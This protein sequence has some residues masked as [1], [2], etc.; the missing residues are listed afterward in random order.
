MESFL[1]RVSQTV[2][3][4]V[5][6]SNLIVVG[7]PVVNEFLSVMSDILS[8]KS[9]FEDHNRACHCSIVHSSG[10]PVVVIKSLIDDVDIN[11]IDFLTNHVEKKLPSQL[12][13]RSFATQGLNYSFDGE[14][15][16]EKDDDGRALGYSGGNTV[17]FVGGFMERML[18]ELVEHILSAVG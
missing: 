17:T 18:P 4:H 13:D 7:N 6:P 9:K 11:L 15:V 1:R 12:V 14:L 3:D 8:F 10:D 16:I 2:A 5:F